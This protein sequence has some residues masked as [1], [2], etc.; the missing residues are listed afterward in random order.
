MAKIRDAAKKSNVTPELILAYC[1]ELDEA[2][3]NHKEKQAHARTAQAR[4]RNIY[5]R[6]KADGITPKVLKAKRD[7]ANQAPEEREQ[8]IREGALIEHA[9]GMHKTFDILQAQQA[10]MDFGEASEEM[11]ERQIRRDAMKDGMDAGRAGHARSTNP[12]ANQPGT[13]AHAAWDNGWIQGDETRKAIGE[14]AAAKEPAGKKDGAAKGT[15]RRG[16]PRKNDGGKV[17]NIADARA[18]KNGDSEKNE[19]FS[20]SAPPPSNGADAE[21]QPPAAS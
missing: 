10:D 18:K 4:I 1:E 14:A 11:K 21:T 20:E 2:E 5:K 13:V 6:A 16:R 12:F 19:A 17:T 9:M 3:E 8:E 7:E 15:G